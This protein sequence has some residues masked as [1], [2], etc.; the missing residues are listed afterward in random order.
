VTLTCT[1]GSSNPMSRISWK[2][3]GFYV[4]D[5]RE[6]TL[7]S[8]FGGIATRSRIF[9]LA[10]PSDDKS[11]FM[12]LAKSDEF[13]TPVSETFTLRVRHSPVFSRTSHTVDVVE[14]SSTTINMTAEAY[15][16][17]IIYI[18]NRNGSLLES[19]DSTK[20]IH[21]KGPVL[22]VQNVSRLDSGI[23]Q[24]IAEN[25]EGQTKATL[26]LNVL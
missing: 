9:L 20:R 19:D 4:R 1:S 22:Y 25:D 6:E 12:C 2:R 13:K 15:P 26:T 3:N 24:C 16:E 8:V 14:R 23:Y 10:T 5:H 21:T 18:W 11:Q 17:H 7:S